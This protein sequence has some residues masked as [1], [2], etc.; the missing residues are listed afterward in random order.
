MLAVMSWSNCALAQNVTI[1]DASFKN[2]VLANVPHPT[3]TTEITISE[4]AAYA[5]AMYIAFQQI[6]NLQGIEAF[7]SLT[8]LDIGYNS[9]SSVN[10]SSNTALTF[11]YCSANNLASLD[12]SHNTSLITLQCTSNLLTSLD[13]SHN[14]HLVDLYCDYNNL[15]SLNVKNGNN[16]NMPHGNG[17]NTGF[18]AL[19]NPNLS[20]ILVDNVAYSTDRKSVV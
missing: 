15:T 5:G 4:A 16:S 3:S 6:S 18:D 2:W 14:I 11:L 20:C 7:T 10:L 17:L 1:P 13:L 9:V 8:S 12:V 19:G